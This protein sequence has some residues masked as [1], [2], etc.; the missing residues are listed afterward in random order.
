MEH[1]ERD[2]LLTLTLAKGLGPILTLRCIRKIG[3][4]QGV[5]AAKASELAGVQGLSRQA[6]LE[7]RRSLDELSDGRKL[8][9][10]KG[11]LEKW[12]A[13]VLAIDDEAYPLSLRHII[14][15]P[16]LLYVRGQLRREDALALAIVGARRC[17][18]YGREQADRLAALCAQMGLCIVSGGAY[19]IDAAAHRAALRAGGR[20]IAVLGSG[21]AK[22]YPPDHAELFDQIVACGG[23]V[24]SELP[25]EFPAMAENF[26]RRNRIISGLSLGVLVIEA[27]LRSGA[28]IT[29]RVAAEEH[30]REVMALPGRVDSPASAGCHRMIREG[31]ATLVTTLED[32]LDAL[33]ETGQLLRA[34]LERRDGGVRTAA[35]PATLFENALTDSQRKV[36]DALFEPAD[37]DV[38]A[39][40]T[41]MP[42]ALI[43]AELTVLEIRGMIGREGGKLHRRRILETNQ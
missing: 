20:T 26:P 35:G 37:L 4:A 39:Q 7:V 23:A 14:D 34:G 3:S 21:L 38:L 24:V 13:S 15:P 6:A 30:H 5:L 29:A 19:G 36:L 17:T 1:A 8:G 16:P 9:E 25:M 42:V 32:I 11:L 10:E 40:R 43:Q 12:G 27:A 28:L 31:W 41:G 18:H 2:A 33:G 22:P